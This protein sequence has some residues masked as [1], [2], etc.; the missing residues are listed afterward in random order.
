[1]SFWDKRNY[2]T[3]PRDRMYRG[4]FF[5]SGHLISALADDASFDF[6]IR[7]GTFVPGRIEIGGYEFSADKSPVLIQM[8]EDVTASN[9]GTLMPI[10]NR[11]RGK[12][13]A[14]NFV[15]PYQGA[16]ISDTGTLIA[17]D[18]LAGNRKEGGNGSGAKLWLPKPDADYAVRVTNLSGQ[19]QDILFTFGWHKEI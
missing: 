12:P 19:S 4:R 10:R 3:D 8:F 2:E 6:F 14:C 17:T 13:D 7:L 18:K 5:S 16:T 15:T 9:N 11:F 1:M